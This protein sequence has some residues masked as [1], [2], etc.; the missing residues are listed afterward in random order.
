MPKKQSRVAK[1]LT[2]ILALVAALAIGLVGGTLIG[3]NSASATPNGAQGAFPGGTAPSNAPANAAGGF[4]SGTIVSVDGDTVTLK[5]TDGS[6]VKVTTADDTTVTTT[7]DSSLDA[8]AEGD[9]V[10][11]V[12]ATDADGNVSATTI[13][14]GASPIGGPAGGAPPTG[15]SN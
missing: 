11:V 10:T 8:L 13:S 15:S 12:G 6:T 5:L 7:K 2:P 3:Q 9:T 14:E 4:T 1:V